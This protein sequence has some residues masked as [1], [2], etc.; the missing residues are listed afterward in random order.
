MSGLIARKLGMSRVFL[1]GAAV[2]VTYLRVEPNVIVRLKNAEKDGYNAII[3]GIGLKKVKTRK[4]KELQKFA[5]MKEWKVQS[6]D[7]LSTGATV[8]AESVPEKSLVTITGVSKGKGFQGTIKRHHFGGGPASHG[9]HFKREPG[10]VGMREMP[11]RI[12]KGKR[13]AGHMGNEQ[14]TVHGRPVVV[15]DKEKGVLA[16]KGPVPGPNGSAVYL[17]VES[18]PSA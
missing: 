7:G 2:A 9:S 12:H 8:T 18:Q 13:M 5:V 6:L 4:G 1:D 10:S 17:T 14:V 15:C 3:L 16:V 11:G